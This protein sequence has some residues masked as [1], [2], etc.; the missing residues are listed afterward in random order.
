M[1]SKAKGTE[2]KKMVLGA[3]GAIAVTTLAFGGISQVIKAAEVGKTQTVPTSYSI[4]YTGAVNSNAL[5]DYVKKDYNVKFV[6]T[7]QPTVNDLRMEEAAELASQNLWRIFRVDL[8]GQTLEMTYN[9]VSSTQQ[10]ARW[11]AN[12]KINDMLSYT[13][14]LDAVTGENHAIAK[15]VYHQADIPE[16]M[17]IN[18]LKNNQEY[19]ALAKEAVEKY[20]IFSGKVKSVEY[21]GQ[22]Y[23]QN[24]KGAKNADITFR[25]TS[26]QGEVVRFTF[27]RYNQ[28][29]LTV[30]FSSWVKEDDLHRELVEQELQ[31]LMEKH[32]QDKS[33]DVIFT[34]E[35]FKEVQENGSPM[36]IE[37]K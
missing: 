13:S 21:D 9:P 29:L 37:I 2:M 33:S 3:I 26:D 6:G 28:E 31:E 17:D 32:G 36:L 12:V 25:V 34:D 22:G 35:M 23:Q 11:E 19:Q 4:A 5:V 20:Q 24:Q 1:M 7:D 15:W 10:R 18:L 30:E 14:T 8:S 27:S 16:G